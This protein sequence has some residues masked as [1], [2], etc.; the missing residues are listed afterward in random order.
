M[1][2]TFDT[3]NKLGF[4]LLVGGAEGH[5]DIL[6]YVNRALSE[7]QSA[8]CQY[9]YIERFKVQRQNT[10]RP[11]DYHYYTVLRVQIPRGTRVNT[12]QMKTIL[13]AR[14]YKVVDVLA[15]ARQLCNPAFT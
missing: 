8:K 15:R 1:A 4:C 10:G 7:T 2:L 14:L 13:E 3:S 5:H 6:R 11:N 9:E 12:M